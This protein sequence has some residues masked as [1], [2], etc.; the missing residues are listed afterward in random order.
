MVE[1]DLTWSKVE[2]KLVRIYQNLLKNEKAG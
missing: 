1:K 2:Q